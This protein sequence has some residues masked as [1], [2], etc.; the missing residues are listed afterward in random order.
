MKISEII[1][2]DVSADEQLKGSDTSNLVVQVLMFLKGRSEEKGLAPKINIDSLV[3]LVHNAGDVTFD[4]PMFVK[5]YEDNPAVKEL[6][7]DFNEDEIIIKTADAAGEELASDAE[8]DTKADEDP[9][10][11]VSNMA[12][13][14]LNN[15]S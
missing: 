4:Y 3:K 11:T 9:E 6:V 14:A 10:T 1:V 12:K 13:K 2:E 15:R 7:Q 5:A 8:E